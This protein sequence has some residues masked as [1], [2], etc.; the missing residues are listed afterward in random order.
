MKKISSI[1]SYIKEYSP[2]GCTVDYFFENQKD[3]VFRLIPKTPDIE[4]HEAIANYISNIRRHNLKPFYVTKTNQMEASFFNNAGTVSFNHNDYLFEDVSN[5]DDPRDLNPHHI[6]GKSVLLS[7]DC[8]DNYFHWMCHILPRI[9]LL[10]E[11]GIDWNEINKIII[12]E[13]RKDFVEQTLSILD[14]PIHKEL[15]IEK[16]TK[17]IFD[18]LIIPSKPNRHIHI[19]PWSIDFLRETFLAKEE[20]QEKKILISRKSTNGRCLQNEDEIFEILSKKGYEKIYLEDYTMYEQASLFNATKEIV[21]IHGAGL[22]NL[23]FCQ[24]NTK[25]IELFN[26]SY[27]SCLYWNICNILNLDYY[28]MIGDGDSIGVDWEN[29]L[30]NIK[31]YHL[32]KKQSIKI[33]IEKFSKL[34]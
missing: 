20:K 30:Q 31:Q 21:A 27:H 9:K 26:P 32:G 11:Y 1:E 28:Y 5:T 19:A 22:T 4:I 33:D 17:Y 23:V 3:T 7:T 15:T 10:E 2:E 24:P 13:T 16:R 29:R 8:G 12:P 25:L 34:I 6:E 14:I 18:S